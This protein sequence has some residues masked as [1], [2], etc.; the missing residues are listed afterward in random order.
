MSNWAGINSKS[1]YCISFFSHQP[2]LNYDNP[3]YAKKVNVM[4]SGGTRSRWFSADAVPYLMKREGSLART[5]GNPRGDREL[6]KKVDDQFP[7]AMLLPRPT[8]AG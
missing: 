3:R 1:Y 6:R 4:S 8:S 5:C 7:G 2:D